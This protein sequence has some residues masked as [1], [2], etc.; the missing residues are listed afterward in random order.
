MTTTTDRAVTDVER[1]GYRVLGRDDLAPAR[2]FEQ[3]LAS[4]VLIGL[5]ERPKRIPSR[6]FYDDEGSRLFQAIMRTPE[7]YPTRTE[8]EILTTHRRTIV[9]QLAG[10]ALDLIDL[11]AGDGA[12]TMLL[13]DELVRRGARFRYVPIDISEGAMKTVVDEVRARFPNVVVDGIVASY[14]DGLDWYAHHRGAGAACVLFLG[15]NI[16]NFDEPNARGYLRRLWKALRPRDHVLIGFDLKKDIDVLLAAYNDEEGVTARFNLN[17]LV[18]LN[19]ELGARFDVSRFRHFG[20][21]DVFTGAMKSYLV[22]LVAQDVWIEELRH[23][24][25]FDAWEPV[26]TEYSYKYLESDVDTLAKATGF[27]IAGRYFDPKR[28][29]TDALFAVEDSNVVR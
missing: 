11:G 18:R 6:F 16:G 27:S 8:T 12:K 20:T 28:W 24:F 26:H 15:S 23:T 1:R 19:R 2:S 9:D 22:S 7:Y 29:F 3:E 17:L 4:E 21:Y 14:T 13:I 10:E 5:S 25:H